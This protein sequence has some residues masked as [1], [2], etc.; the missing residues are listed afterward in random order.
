[1]NATQIQNQISEL[2]AKKQEIQFHNSSIERARKEFEKQWNE[3]ET[4][5]RKNYEIYV[6]RLKQVSI[7]E[8]EILNTIKELVPDDVYQHLYEG[9][10]KIRISDNLMQLNGIHHKYRDNRKM[11]QLLKL[12][13]AVYRYNRNVIFNVPST[14]EIKSRIKH[15]S[16]CPDCGEVSKQVLMSMVMNQTIILP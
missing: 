14:T 15:A 10:P 8:T 5:K 12:I 9:F 13:F 16:T 3:T 11:R 6:D 1:M 2:L 4:K 7:L